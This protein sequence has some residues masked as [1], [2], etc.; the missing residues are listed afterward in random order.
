MLGA[1]RTT[2]DPGAAGR[3]TDSPQVVEPVASAFG[4][5]EDAMALADGVP[6]TAAQER[7]PTEATAFAIRID[8]AEELTGWM[9]ISTRSN[10]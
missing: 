1:H 10:A 7:A 4:P 8:V 6:P 5:L 2:P 9:R 3:P